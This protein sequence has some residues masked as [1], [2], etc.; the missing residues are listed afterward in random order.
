VTDKMGETA[1]H[2]AFS[3]D[4]LF[5]ENFASIVQAGGDLSL[6]NH[7]GKTSRQMARDREAERPELEISYPDVW[8]LVCSEV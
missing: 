5:A 4:S 7:G 8:R 2:R 6:K 1:L 3:S